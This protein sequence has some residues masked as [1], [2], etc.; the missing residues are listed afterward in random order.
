MGA[1]GSLLGGSWALPAASLA[2][3]GL[4]G[5]SWMSI[6]ALLETFGAQK[7]NWKWLL[8]GPRRPRRPVSALLGG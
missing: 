7:S 2:L 8:D 1:L 4:S 6:G 5:R 3:W